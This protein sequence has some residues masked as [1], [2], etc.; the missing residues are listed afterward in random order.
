M[1]AAEKHEKLVDLRYGPYITPVIAIGVVVP[2]EVRGLV[3]LV[4]Q[5][6]GPIPWPI[7]QRDGD[8]QLIVFKALARAVRQESPHAVARAWGVTVATVEAWRTACRQPIHR[9][10]QTVSSPPIPW[11][12]DDDELISR[13]SLAEAARL[14]GRTITAVRK[15]RRALGLP[16]G[17]MAAQRA[18]KT[19]GNIENR[20]AAVRRMLRA[21]TLELA[22]SLAELRETFQRARASLA[23]WRSQPSRRFSRNRQIER[24][25]I[26]GKPEKNV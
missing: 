21:R 14:T 1:D 23:F 17:R 26:S 9:K 3:T 13:L 24:S 20:A 19:E 10:K 7:G 25:S 4:G 2:C 15:R 8:Q 11:K 6:D 18:I 16:D 22:S 12:H 5:T